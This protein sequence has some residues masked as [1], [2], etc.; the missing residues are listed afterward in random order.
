MFNNKDMRI[1]VS[2]PYL[3]IKNKNTSLDYILKYF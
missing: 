2:Y 3:Y 1:Y